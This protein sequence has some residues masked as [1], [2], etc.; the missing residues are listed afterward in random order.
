MTVKRVGQK[1]APKKKTVRRKPTGSLEL[2]LPTE[3][4]EVNDNFFD[5]ITLIYGRPGIGKT[6][7]AASYPNA[8]LFSCERVS[9]GIKCYDFNTENKGPGVNTWEVFREGVKLLK[10]SNQFETVVIDTVASAYAHCLEWKCDDLG[11]PYPKDNDY[12]KSWG[13]VKEEFENQLNQI[14]KTGRKLVFTAHANEREIETH[15]GEKYTRIEPLMSSGAQKI[16]KAITDFVFYADFVKI[17][18]KSKRV[19][20]TT[21]D[22]IIDAKHAELES[23]TFPRYLPLKAK[24]GAQVV[25]EAF[26]GKDVGIDPDLIKPEKRTSDVAA[27]SIA[28]EATKKKL[29]RIK[30]KKSRK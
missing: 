27:E 3:M 12:G 2:A 18:G 24:N 22:E 28:N 23:E 16:C 7:F 5:Y 21:G 4:K 13:A 9:P 19:L 11:I 20:F 14:R 29:A 25:L 10:K 26:L 30:K 8:V 17:D 15:S 1:A 6:T